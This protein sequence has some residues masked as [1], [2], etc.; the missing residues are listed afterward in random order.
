MSSEHVLEEPRQGGRVPPQDVAAER[1]VLGAILLSADAFVE[2]ASS[3]NADDFYRPA[4][5][6][7]F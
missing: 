5:A 4:H 3:L 7:I 6:R 1:S 2:I